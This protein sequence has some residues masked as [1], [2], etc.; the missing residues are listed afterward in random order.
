MSGSQSVIRMVDEERNAHAGNAVEKP[1]EVVLRML[2]YDQMAA[3]LQPVEVVI[4][5]LD[6]AYGLERHDV[7]D[8][9][10]EGVVAAIDEE[11]PQ[12]V[13]PAVDDGADVVGHQEAENGGGGQGQDLVEAGAESHA[14]GHP[15]AEGPHCGRIE[16]RE[17]PR[18]RDAPQCVAQQKADAKEETAHEVAVAALH[19]GDDAQLPRRL[20]EQGQIEGRHHRR[21]HSDGC[22]GGVEGIRPVPAAPVGEHSSAGGDQLVGR[23]EEN[24][25]HEEG[26][27]EPEG[28]GQELV[29]ASHEKT[30]LHAFCWLWC[31]V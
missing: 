11:A 18:L 13:V 21:P 22:R 31:Q 8:E 26:A 15:S 7:E 29:V 17:P 1:E 9:H 2:V 3:H 28:P 6:E 12:G 10:A 14:R 19:E 27:E 24:A 16:Q 20:P 5:Y 4:P 30:M 25:G 23:Q